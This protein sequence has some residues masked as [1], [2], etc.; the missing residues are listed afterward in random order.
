MKI[1]LNTNYYYSP[2]RMFGNRS[3]STHDWNDLGSGF[4]ADFRV[5]VRIW[6]RDRHLG[7]YFRVTVRVGFRVTALHRRIVVVV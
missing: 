5:T 7:L 4:E 3:G 6:F 2:V 1:C